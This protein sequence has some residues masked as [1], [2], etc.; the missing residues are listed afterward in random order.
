MHRRNFLGLTAGGILL[1]VKPP[2]LSIR[3]F[4]EK[5]FGVTIAHN[6]YVEDTL[7]WQTVYKYTNKNGKSSFPYLPLPI[8]LKYQVGKLVQPKVGKIFACKKQPF[9]LSQDARLFKCKAKNVKPAPDY[10]LSIDIEK[11]D[12][13]CDYWNGNYKNS[14]VMT[15]EQGENGVIC[16]KLKVIR[17]IFR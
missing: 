14:I 16:D 13:I 4:L 15:P 7:S 10:V 5:T 8:V 1:P 3:T 11:I 9:N 6:F 12:L 17:E 2:W